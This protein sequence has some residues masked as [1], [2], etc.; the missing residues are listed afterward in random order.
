MDFIILLRVEHNE[1]SFA[2]PFGTK[3][4]IT[5]AHWSMSWVLDVRFFMDGELCS[6]GSHKHRSAHSLVSALMHHSRS[7]AWVRVSGRKWL[8]SRAC[9]RTSGHEWALSWVGVSVHERGSL[10]SWF[11]LGFIL[12]IEPCS[13]LSLCVVFSCN[14]IWPPLKA[15]VFIESNVCGEQPCKSC[16]S[17]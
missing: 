4:F 2:L 16:F 13:E 14:N 10:C 11:L 6:S 1:C 5:I 7:R 12:T 17:A 15:V 8:R 9:V 3:F